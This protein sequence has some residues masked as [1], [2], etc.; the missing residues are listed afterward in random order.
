MNVGIVFVR[1][2]VSLSTLK[3]NVLS[4]SE[5]QLFFRKKGLLTFFFC[6]ER[7]IIFYFMWSSQN[8]SSPDDTVGHNDII[9]KSE[10]RNALATL[11][12]HE[13]GK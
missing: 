9:V 10:Q 5:K 8:L 6:V 7:I 2:A 12:N 11:P 13:W 4:S 1:E 3:M